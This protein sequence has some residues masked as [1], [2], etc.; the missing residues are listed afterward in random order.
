MADKM[1]SI[2]VGKPFDIA[3]HLEENNYLG[4][5]SLILNLQDVKIDS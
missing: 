5:K 1:E 4:N 3:Y 2:E